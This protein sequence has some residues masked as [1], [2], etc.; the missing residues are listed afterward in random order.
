MHC[1]SLVKWNYSDNL[2]IDKKKTIRFVLLTASNDI[3]PFYSP[4]FLL[5]IQIG[6]QERHSIMNLLLICL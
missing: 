5:L 2:F 1:F 4:L 6:E 3:V